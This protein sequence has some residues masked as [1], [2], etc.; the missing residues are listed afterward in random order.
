[1][2]LA[3]G[4]LG[5]QKECIAALGVKTD[6]RTNIQTPNGKYST[7]VPGVFAAGDCRRGQS[8]VV[9]GI[10][11]GRQAAE[12]VDAFLVGNTRLAHQGGIPTRSWLPPTISKSL[13]A[14]SEMASEK[15][16]MD[17]EAVTVAATA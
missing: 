12:E 14:I 16:G 2:L 13:D 1:M 5:P 4:F 15:A 11:E 3:L 17:P 7:S 10:K 8:L 6:P 9:W